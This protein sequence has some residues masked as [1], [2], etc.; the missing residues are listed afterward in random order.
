ME[1]SKQTFALDEAYL[2]KKI[3]LFTNIQLGCI[4][5]ALMLM[6]MNLSTVV[7]LA[8]FGALLILASWYKHH[9]S[10]VLEDAAELR[11]SFS[12]KS[13]LITSKQ[14]EQEQRITFRS[15][16][17]QSL[18]KENLIPVVTLYLDEGEPVK[19]NGLAEPEAFLNALQTAKAEH[20][21]SA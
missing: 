15:I 7:M 20:L 11:V 1:H 13:I 19:L 4:G 14:A 18:H 9:I 16:Q 12:P 2:E 8:I 3:K 17:D 10:T 21:A 6:M 5:A